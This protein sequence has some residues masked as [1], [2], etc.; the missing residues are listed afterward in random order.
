MAPSHGLASVLSV[1]L[2]SLVGCATSEPRAASASASETTPA[3]QET[4]S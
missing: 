2:I 4:C 3:S 1:L